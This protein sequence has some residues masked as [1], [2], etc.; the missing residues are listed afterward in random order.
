MPEKPESIVL[1]GGCFWCLEAIF[2]RV[3]GVQKVNSG[4]SGGK[5]KN[6]SYQEVCKGQTGHAEVVKV[7]FDSN[8]TSLEKI[9]ELF[10]EAHDPTTLNRQGADLGTQYRSV[11]FVFNQ[12]QLKIAKTSKEKINK[13]KLYKDPVVTEIKAIE[14]FYQAESYHQNYYKNNS[15]QPYCRAIIAPKLKKLSSNSYLSSNS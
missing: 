1:G 5:T 9:L 11:I 13:S 8:K 2:Q 7:D 10:W 3:T 4:Y 12:D 15:S 6:P 14:S